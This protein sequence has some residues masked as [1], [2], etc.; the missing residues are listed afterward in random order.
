MKSTC[1]LSTDDERHLTPDGLPP[2]LPL[3]RTS[4]A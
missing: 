4:A 1:D 3:Q 2:N